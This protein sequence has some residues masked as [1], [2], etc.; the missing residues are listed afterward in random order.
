MGGA[1]L[2]RVWRT[3]WCGQLANIWSQGGQQQSFGV[4]LV[5]DVHSE[6]RDG[7][8]FVDRRIIIFVEEGSS[9]IFDQSAQIDEGRRQ[10]ERRWNHYCSLIVR[11]TFL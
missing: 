11:Q 10:S 2:F 6:E 7:T 9:R 3:F 4:R 5:A 1:S 8:G